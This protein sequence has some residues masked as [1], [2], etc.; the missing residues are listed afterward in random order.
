MATLDNIGGKGEK[1]FL[2]ST[3]DYGI[4]AFRARWPFRDSEDSAEVVLAE[5]GSEF[6]WQALAEAVPEEAGN[7]AECFQISFLNISD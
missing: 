6:W 5:A 7:P 3:C 4:Y 2:L 1:V